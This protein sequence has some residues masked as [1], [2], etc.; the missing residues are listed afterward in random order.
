MSK[1]YALDGIAGNVELAKGGIRV[2]D[3]A[4][5]LEAR[6]NADSGFVGV[7]ASDF[8]AV[9]LTTLGSSGN[10]LREDGTYQAVPTSLP[11]S[12]AASGD[13]SGTYPGP[14]V[15]AITETTGPTQ[16]TIGAV[17]DGDF[18]TRSGAT[19]VGGSPTIDIQ[20]EGVSQGQVS[21]IDY[22]GAGV[23][24]TVAAGTATVTIAGGGG[25]LAGEELFS[26]CQATTQNFP[27]TGAPGGFGN[28]YSAIVV[29]PQTTVA[30]TV[31]TGLVTQAPGGLGG[32]A[33]GIYDQL[34]N[35]LANTAI[36]SAIVGINSLPIT[37]GVG[38]VLL[39]GVAYYLSTY[40]NQNG[41]RVLGTTGITGTPAG[42][43]P[44]GFLVPNSGSIDATGFPANINAFLGS[45]STERFWVLAN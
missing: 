37:V 19:L 30:L 24:A 8:N 38:T 17:A 22:V 28:L 12:G 13:L 39:G 15:A 20:D 35:R 5:A 36:T 45:Q 40:V 1:N 23:T 26:L 11:P 42:V 32:I 31:L 9:A 25:S 33:F 29:V 7:V 4:G 16:L 10:S 3:N 43:P 21:S 34:G 18:L 44:G 27:W 41:V 2:R 14:S 6:N